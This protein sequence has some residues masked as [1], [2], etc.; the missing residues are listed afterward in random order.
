MRQSLQKN[1]AFFLQGLLFLCKKAVFELSFGILAEKR[2]ISYARMVVWSKSKQASRS[3]Q[4]EVSKSMG[5]EIG[6]GN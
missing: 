4:V 2:G 6:T 1:Q 3:K 5:E